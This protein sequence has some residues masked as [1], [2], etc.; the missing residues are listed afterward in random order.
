MAKLTAKQKLFVQEYLVDLNASQ[1]AL[2]A[3]YSKKT[4]YRIGA[5]LLQ[6]TSVSNAIHKAMDERAKRTQVT[7]DK[8]VTE[9]AKVGFCSARDVMEWGPGGVRLKESSE[10]TADQAATVAE[11]SET[12]TKDGGSLRLKQHDKIRALELLGKHL[13]MFLDKKEITGANGGDFKIVLFGDSNGNADPS[14]E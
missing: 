13:G 1:A 12:T 9:L 7:A 10:L 4:A 14:Q 6:K 3:G 8:V 5:E 2:R 11:V